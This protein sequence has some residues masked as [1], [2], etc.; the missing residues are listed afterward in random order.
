MWPLA[1]MIEAVALLFMGASAWLLVSGVFAAAV[2]ELKESPESYALFSHLDVAVQVPNVVPAALVLL[3][4][5]G[6]LAAHAKHC[7][8][9]LL[10]LGVADAIWLAFASTV[11]TER[12][13]VG[14]L[15]GAA[16][17]G[18]IGT[19]AMVAFFPFAAARHGPRS[20][21]ALSAGIGCSGLVAQVFG[22]AARGGKAY[23]TSPQFQLGSFVNPLA[24]G[25]KMS[26][27]A[28]LSH[29]LW[30]CGRL[31]SFRSA[32]FWIPRRDPVS[33]ADQRRG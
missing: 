3:T 29:I 32:R 1:H 4:P 9:G 8:A 15:V 19:T 17:G 18:L 25:L 20:I 27:R 30:C 21:T 7:C 26:L 5:E 28:G 12:T 14:M 31:A 16:C 2:W 23:V 13:S 22:A 11:R 10:A 33:L 6:W 24:T